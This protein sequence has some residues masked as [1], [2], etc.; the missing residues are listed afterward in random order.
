[1][2]INVGADLTNVDFFVEIINA[3]PFEFTTS[4][5]TGTLTNW[6]NVV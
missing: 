2:T 5:I 1:M 4:A 3:Q 6:G